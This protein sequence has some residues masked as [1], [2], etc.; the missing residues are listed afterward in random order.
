MVALRQ[1]AGARHAV[2]RLNVVALCALIIIVVFGSAGKLG[3][4]G[5]YFGHYGLLSYDATDCS[6]SDESL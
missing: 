1:S 5:C 3:V 2:F 4:E 6:V